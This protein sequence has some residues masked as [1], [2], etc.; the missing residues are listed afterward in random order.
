MCFHLSAR[1]DSKD[2]EGAE[3]D[4]KKPK[5][6]K[7]G[8]PEVIPTCPRGLC[9]FLTPA[10]GVLAIT[11]HSSALFFVFLSPCPGLDGAIKSRMQMVALYG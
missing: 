11:L 2:K 9:S 1:I 8:E 4:E 7:G 10:L 5:V 6:S 3:T